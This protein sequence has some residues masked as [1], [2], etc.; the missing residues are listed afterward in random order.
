VI[1]FAARRLGWAVVTA[2]LASV[3]AFVLFWTIPNVDPEYFLGGAEKGNEFTRARAVEKYGL[4]DPL[5]VQYERLMKEILKGDVECFY[6]CGSV[7][8]AFVEALPVTLSLVAGAALIAVGLGVSLALV[9]VRH[10]GR[11]PDRVITA[12]ATAAYSMPSLVLASLLWGFLAYKWGIFP[13]RDYV[14]LTENPFQW[15]WHLLLPWIAASLP[16]AGAYVQVVRASL[17][18]AVDLDYV[19]TARAKGLSEKRVLRRHVLRN[20]LIPPVNIW[21]LDFSHAFGGYALYVEVIFGL[22]G[23]G[24]LTS[25]TLS[26]LDLPPIVALAVYLSIVVVLTSAV[27]DVI[28]AWIDPRIRQSASSAA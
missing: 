8:A 16:F 9:C 15:A 6:G 11:W 24:L 25:E 26:S 20:A 3:V 5:P 2:F 17:L 22:P 28:V 4:D 21:G 18:E 12:A 19:R 14:P 27:V 1:A 13:E 23:I 10:R 7:R